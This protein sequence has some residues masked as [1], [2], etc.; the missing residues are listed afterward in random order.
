MTTAAFDQQPAVISSPGPA[1]AARPA[2]PAQ[3]WTPDLAGVLSIQVDSERA[4]P[5]DVWGEASGR[6]FH[7]FSR[8]GRLEHFCSTPATYPVRIRFYVDSAASPRPQPFRPPSLSVAAAFT[9]TGGAR[10]SVAGV[11]DSSPR[12]HGP[13]WPLTPSFGDLFSAVSSAS[14]VLAVTARLAD[15]DAGVTLTY[16]DDIACELVPCA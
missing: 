11:T 2:I 9:P 4:A 7:P 12:Y 13:G 15:T 8:R 1:P 14:G 16:T 6:G 3:T 5:R 10:R